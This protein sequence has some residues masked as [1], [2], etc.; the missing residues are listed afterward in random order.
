MPEE[1]IKPPLPPEPE[2]PPTRLTLSTAN[3]EAPTHDDVQAMYTTSKENRDVVVE[4]IWTEESLNKSFDLIVVF[5]LIKDRDFWDYELRDDPTWTLSQDRG[6]GNNQVIWNYKT[7]DLALVDEIVRMVRAN[8][9]DQI[10][11]KHSHEVAVA[12]V[13]PTKIFSHYLVDPMRLLQQGAS[14]GLQDIS[15]VLYALAARYFTGKAEFTHNREIAQ[16]FFEQGTPVDSYYSGATGDAVMREIL[17][18]QVA[19]VG[20][21]AEERSH[22]KTITRHMQ[23]L[24]REGMALLEQKKYLA[25]CNLTYESLP[26]NVDIP[27]PQL[28]STVTQHERRIFDHCDGHTKLSEVVRTA[29]M[30]TWEWAPVLCNLVTRRLI[31]LRPPLMKR[32]LAAQFAPDTADDTISKLHRLY[33]PQ[34]G[35]LSYH[36]LILYIQR[37]FFLFLDNKTPLSLV[38]FDVQIISPT[39]SRPRSLSAK[40]ATALGQKFDFFKRPLDVFGHFETF[41]YAVLLPNT[42]LKQATIVAKQHVQMLME[43]DLSDDPELAAAGRLLVSCGVASLPHHGSDLDCLI[44]SA[45]SAKHLAKQRKISLL[46]GRPKEAEAVDDEQDISGRRDAALA[47]APDTVTKEF[48]KIEVG[49]LLIRASLVSP[50]HVALANQLIA[51]MPAPLPIGRVLAM[52]GHIREETVEAAIRILPLIACGKLTIDHAISALQLIGNHSLDFDSAMMRM[53]AAPS[54]SKFNPLAKLLKDSDILF[55]KD[56][57]KAIRESANTGLPVGYVLVCKGI[58]PRSMLHALLFTASLLQRG[59]ILN[60]EAVKVIYNMAHSSISLEEALQDAAIEAEPEFDLAELLYSGGILSEMQYTS[61]CEIKMVERKPIADVL[62]DAGF[63]PEPI[64]SCAK[65]LLDAVRRLKLTQDHAAKVLKSIKYATTVPNISELIANVENN[66]RPE[67]VVE[68]DRVELLKSAG[69]FNSK[70]LEVIKPLAEEPEQKSLLRTLLTAG[71]IDQQTLD[72]T[73]WAKRTIE[74]GDLDPEQAII[75]LKYCKDQGVSFEQAVD[76]FSWRPAT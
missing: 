14:S 9:A 73:G 46:I 72:A 25:K 29:S 4:W 60:S 28:S 39:E 35:L 36:A 8:E 15:K 74:A 45:K 43:T 3:D 12:N 19:A 63:L 42:D 34:T 62:T 71:I 41:D 65:Q 44:T 70:Q 54:R 16:I 26:C 1:L 37:E 61:V 59:R 47:D 38:V 68:V 18:W 5:P 30:E 48:P 76:L 22:H 21:V 24:L 69:Y 27:E 66:R 50:Q 2:K 20:F 67:G 52:E 11:S 23:N 75:L 55:E 10:A 58:L 6:K 49:E 57:R 64:A 56:L 40:E 33:A 7:S 17:S 51:R 32:P 53:G 13:I 31:E